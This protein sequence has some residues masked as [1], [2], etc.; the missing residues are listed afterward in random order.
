ME[1]KIF[2]LFFITCELVD[3]AEQYENLSSRKTVTV[4]TRYN[5]GYF[6]PSKAVDE[7]RSTYLLDCSLTA[8]DQEEAWLT[9]DL[10]E[11]KNIASITILHGGFGLN[12]SAI[13]SAES[14]LFP[15]LNGQVFVANQLRRICTSRFDEKDAQ[16]VC[17]AW[18]FLPDNPIYNIARDSS[19]APFYNILNCASNEVNINTCTKGS[20]DCPSGSAVALTCQKGSTLSGFSVYVSDTEDWRSGTLCYQY[21]VT[22]IPQNNIN[23]DCV[24]SGRYV[25]V[26]NTRNITIYPNVS[27]FSYINICEIEVKG[28]DMGFYGE[29]C[30]RCPK[31]CLN[32]TCHFQ[33]GYC[34]DCSDGYIGRYCETECAAGKYGQGCS[35]KCGQCIDDKPCNH[36][37]GSCPGDCSAGW[38]GD[39]CDQE[40]EHGHFGLMC[41]E[42]CSQH[43]LECMSCDHVSGS[44]D[45][46][47]KDGWIGAKCRDPCASTFYGVTC[48]QSCSN[49]CRD[50]ICNPETGYCIRCNEGKS[51]EFCQNEI[52]TSEPTISKNM[53]ILAV[54]L[55]AVVIM[56]L[57]AT[58]VLCF[59]QRNCRPSNSSNSDPVYERTVARKEDKS[60]YADIHDPMSNKNTGI[61][62]S[63][64]MEISNNDVKSR[65]EYINLG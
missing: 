43:C 22:Q 44:C 45:G 47:C 9:V 28:C 10:G 3:N 26:Y 33:I 8:S 6:S 31:N 40:C 32:K 63:H 61:D 41:K 19:S 37:N 64:Y 55:L 27:E 23:L 48:N 16:V 25:T 15:T 12:A 4:S 50:N 20:P 39:R 54:S 49:D 13:R 56:L 34:F 65:T 57:V 7:D 30:T 53:F 60:E 36:V 29:S 21:D 35:V 46:G 58:L 59:L 38:R 5:D 24:T 42:H 18:G 14:G 1:S 17:L 11:K 2:N 51:G 52:T 62:T